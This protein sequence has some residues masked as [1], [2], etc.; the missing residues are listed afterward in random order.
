MTGI[1]TLPKDYENSFPNFLIFIHLTVHWLNFEV[2][3]PL[4]ISIP[5]TLMFEKYNIQSDFC[6]SLA[7]F[8]IS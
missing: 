6:H 7:Y 4:V 8:I 3:V 5:T 2:Q 1:L